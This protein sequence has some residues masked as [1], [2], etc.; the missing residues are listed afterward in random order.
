M[1]RRAGRDLRR[2][3]PRRHGRWLQG[4]ALRRRQPDASA[5][6]TTP[7]C[8]RH[9]PVRR[10]HRRERARHVR[11]DRTREDG[12]LVTPAMLS[13]ARVAARQPGAGPA[14]GDARQPGLQRRH[15]R[16]VRR[17]RRLP[18]PAA[19]VVVA[20][21]HPR[22]RERL[23]PRRHD[24]LLGLARHP[25]ARAGRPHRP[26]A[27]RPALD[28]L[29]HQQPRAVAQRRRQPR[30]RRRPS[31]AW[32]S[33]TCPRCRPAGRPR[34][35]R[36]QPPDVGDDEH[37]AERHADHDRRPPLRRRDRRVRGAGRRSGAGRIIDIAD[38]TKPQVVSNLR[39]EVHQPENFD[40]S[41]RRPGRVEPDPGLRRPLLQ[42]AAARVDPASSPA[43]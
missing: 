32:S 38:E 17:H 11:P 26:D 33:S 12:S 41:R 10:Q 39:L 16:R 25:D 7:R 35:P 5:R 22:P 29:P 36:G 3:R 27:A 1:Q 30:L 2:R 14:G 15:R 9:R 42:R 19:A 34:S 8:F 37:P 4:G 40:R 18:A 20:G 21:G 6:T 43:R 28:Q 13:P 23:R 24:L 31:T